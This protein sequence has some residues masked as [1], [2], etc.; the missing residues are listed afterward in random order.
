MSA[1]ETKNYESEKSSF[2]KRYELEAFLSAVLFLLT[3]REDYAGFEPASIFF[4]I[5]LLPMSG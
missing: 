1:P 4:R 5:W 2:S 3:R